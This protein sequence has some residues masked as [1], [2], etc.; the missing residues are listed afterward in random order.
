MTISADTLREVVPIKDVIGQYVDLREHGTEYIGACPFC[1]LEGEPFIV[2]PEKRTYVCSTCGESGDVVRF[3]G[4][5]I[6]MTQAESI[7][8]LAEMFHVAQP[9]PAE[10]TSVTYTPLADSTKPV[11]GVVD[12]NTIRAPRAAADNE[13]LP[14][15]YSEDHMADAFA[16]AHSASM[17]YVSTWGAWMRWDGRLWRK[18]TVLEAFDKAR[19]ICREYA[20]QASQDASLGARRQTI[21]MSLAR[22]NTM[23][24]VERAAKSDVRIAREADAWDADPWLLNTPGGLVNL[25]TG[26]LSPHDIDAHCTKITR[27]TPQGDCPA[28]LAFLDVATQGNQELQAY[29][30]RIAG[31]ALTGD[32][33][34]E[35]LFFVHGSG[36]NGK[37]TFI[38][39]IQWI[40][41]DYAA[42][43]SMETFTESR[44]ERHTTDLAML[45]GARLVTAQETEEGK[46]WAESRL[47]SITGGDPITARFMRADNFTFTPQFKLLIAGNNKPGIRS[48]DEA[49]RRRMN[50]IPFTVSIPEDAKD[51]RL[52]ERL[53]G[54]ADGILAWMVAG[55]LAWQKHGLRPPEI[56]KAATDE[57][58]SAEDHL[59]AWLSECCEIDESYRCKRQTLF[60]SYRDWAKENGE[61]CPSKGRWEAWMDAKG[62]E[63]GVKDGQKI[64]KGLTKKQDEEEL[65]RFGVIDERDID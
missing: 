8:W 40:L 12:G 5:L 38:N 53:K 47:K 23:A 55:C 11:L 64:Y 36:G 32:I 18:D 27:A 41:N 45:Q 29:M 44:N 1:G 10:C 59:S 7:A 61:F 13:A 15:E 21:P 28:W 43:A 63:K 56:V 2:S 39:T 62:Y 49:M 48:V 42:V 31:Y 19:M 54:E 34:E 16:R 50:L 14:P 33:S 58:L 6:Q 57:Y 60:H 46:R 3:V 51:K 65:L 30:Q 37:G 20:R 25:R 24:A 4:H 22:A 52:K 26:T 17:R 9:A 35:C